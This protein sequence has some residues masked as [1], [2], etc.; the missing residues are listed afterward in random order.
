[1][2]L[3]IVMKSWLLKIIFVFL[4]AIAGFL[5]YEYDNHADYFRAQK[6]FVTLPPGKTLKILSF[7]FHNL[8][9]DMLYIWSIQFYSNYNLTNSYLYLEDIY[10]AITDLSPR[11]K[12]PY[13]VGS[14]IMAIEAKQP[15][16]AIR[17]LQKGKKNMPDDWMFDSESG[18]CAYKYKKDLKLAEYYYSLAASNPNAPE[19]L[20]RQKAHMIFL[21]DDWDDAYIV[22]LDIYKKAKD[23]LERTSATNHLRQIKF[24]IDNRMFQARISSFVQTYKRFPRSLN[25]LQ[26]VGLIDEIPKDFD[27]KDYI[28]DP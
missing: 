15:E 12:E 1:M 8:T 7:G 19:F 6:T 11:Y 10:N 14:W 2:K 3:Q 26:R 21:E 18:Y 17:L 13:L 22:W 27:G 23:D 20:K 28:Y 25:E 5:Q 9:A 4:I 24:E 16:M